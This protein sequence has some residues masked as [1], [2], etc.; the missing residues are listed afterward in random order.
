MTALASTGELGEFVAKLMSAA[1]ERLGRDVALVANLVGDFFT[2][3]HF[4]DIAADYAAGMAE[5][6]AKDKAYGADLNVMIDNAVAG[7]KKLLAAQHVDTRPPPPSSAQ[8]NTSA[9][10]A[11]MSAAQEQIK[12]TDEVYQQAVEKLSSEV[13]LHQITYSQETQALLTA[14]DARHA[15]ELAALA[16]EQQIGGLSASQYQKITNEKLQVDQK[17]AQDR[18]KVMD[19]AQQKEINDWKSA[20]GPIESAFNSQINSLLEGTETFGQ[21]M[22]KVFASMV[23]D[24]I[25][26]LLDLAIEEAIVFAVTGSFGSVGSM[27]TGVVGGIGK[28]L[29]FDVGTNYVTQSGLAIIHEG[30]QIVPAQGSGPYS[31]DG[32]GGIGSGGGTGPMVQFH[33]NGPVIGNQAWINSMMPQLTRAMNGYQN[34]NPSVA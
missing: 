6:E 32:G 24:I 25:K 19:Q 14:L 21:A 18:Q 4:S 16:K 28:V 33:F 34:I 13:K 12:L 26:E 17:Y 29:G 27:G 15:A 11:A 20:V 9:I 22:K 23:E 7:Y 10:S 8:P 5:I 1:W 3:A 2:K 31:G 30:E